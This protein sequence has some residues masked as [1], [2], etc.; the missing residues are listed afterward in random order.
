MF[1]LGLIVASASLLA[2]C[3]AAKPAA[4]PTPVPKPP[5]VVNTIPVSDR[6]FVTLRPNTDGRG[7]I[8]VLQDLKK[9]A[10]AGEYEIEYQTGTLLQGAFGRLAMSPLPN[11][12]N[13][14]LGSCSAGGKCTYHEN[15]TGGSILLRFTDPEK[16]ALKNDWSYHK[17]TDKQTSFSSQDGKFVLASPALAQSSAVVVLQTPGIPAG[18]KPAPLSLGYAPAVGGKL[19][20]SVTVSLRLNEDKKATIMGWDGQAWKSLKTTVTEAKVVQT[21]GPLHAAYVAVAQE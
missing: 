3:G 17:N 7:L 15:V 20:A 5:E 13:I 19:P 18:L 11:E 21:T 1:G 10:T 9:P 14:L 16:Y 8:L 4:S 12:K 2:G 6:P